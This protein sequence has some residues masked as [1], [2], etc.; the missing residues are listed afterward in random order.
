MTLKIDN[1]NP[2]YKNEVILKNIKPQRLA[3]N[4]SFISKDKKYSYYG[5]SMQKADKISLLSK[6]M[7]LS[8]DDFTII[9]NRHRDQGLER[10]DELEGQ[11]HIHPD[12]VSSKRFDKCLDGFWVFRLGGKK[13]R[14]IGKIYKTTFYVLG[15]DTSFSAY[16]H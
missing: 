16:K 9:M 3:F 10:L 13:G 6:M 1:G 11:M 15:I 2:I 4:F 12:F 8:E 7:I 5:N 14:V